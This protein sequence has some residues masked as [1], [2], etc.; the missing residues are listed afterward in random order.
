MSNG[1]VMRCMRLICCVSLSLF[2]G[3]SIHCSGVNSQ[4]SS[5]HY[6]DSFSKGMNIFFM[7][8]RNDF[9]PADFSESLSRLKKDGI[10]DLFL[11]PYYFSPDEYSDTI[12]PT[13]QTIE[14]S[15]LTTAVRLSQDSGF[16][17]AL[18]PHIDLLNG[19]PRYRINP[20]AM[21]K[22][23]EQYAAFIM[24]YVV[25]STAM[26]LSRFVIGTEL[27]HVSETDEFAAIIAKARTIYNGQILYA[28][29][30]DHFID[31]KIWRH[32]DAIGVDA[33]F[34]LDDAQ[35]HSMNALM[36]SWN[37]WL[38]LI[39][40]VASNYDKPVIITEV[41]Y[42]SRDGAASNPGSWE[43]SAN[44]NGKIQADCYK[45][46]LSQACS[47]KKITGIFLWQLELGGAGGA[48]N[49]DYTPRDKPAE[50]VIKDYWGR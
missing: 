49:C 34:N 29:S 14:D 50:Q 32:V 20:G 13:G 6:P 5:S 19:C 30:Y 7:P 26:G 16:A 11:I 15:A 40:E 46:L 33:Y 1:S 18:K 37:Y 21:Q 35:E 48:D 42:C 4:G 44:Y 9:T 36:E 24:K 12:F 43:T 10:T 22:W 38:N 17:V 45:A 2:L 47:F 8:P 41:G 39:S 28:A 31:A 25:F 3:L 27:D 23:A